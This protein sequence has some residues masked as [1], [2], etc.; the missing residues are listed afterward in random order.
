MDKDEKITIFLEK[1]NKELFP[2]H[3]EDITN[4]KMI[5]I[6]Q[7][8]VG[9]LHSFFESDINLRNDLIW[10]LEIRYDK[11]LYVIQVFDMVK[12]DKVINS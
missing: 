9:L 1:W 8:T 3:K 11:D 5:G 7:D 4:N 10:A 2:I 12:L 6:T